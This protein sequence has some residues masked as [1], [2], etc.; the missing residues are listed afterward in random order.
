M[1][2]TISGRLVRWP[3]YPRTAVCP[4]CDLW[5]TDSYWQ[6]SDALRQSSDVRCWGM[7]RPKSAAPEG[8]LLTRMYGPAVRCKW[9]SPS[10]R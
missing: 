2:F 9:I 5:V 4:K 6:F 8:R 3:S 7:N 10:W 1:T